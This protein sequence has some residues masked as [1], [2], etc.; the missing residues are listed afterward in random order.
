[1]VCE[2]CSNE[3]GTRLDEV[4][5]VVEHEERGVFRQGGD[6]LLDG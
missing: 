3:L 5:A 2:E 1:V 6:E 4:L